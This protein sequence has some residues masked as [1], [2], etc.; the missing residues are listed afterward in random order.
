M[1]KGGW[2][3]R[4]RATLRDDTLDEDAKVERLYEF[5]DEAATDAVSRQNWGPGWD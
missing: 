4:I 2:C 3:E 5:M 1:N